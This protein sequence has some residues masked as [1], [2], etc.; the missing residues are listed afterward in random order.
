MPSPPVGPGASGRAARE[1]HLAELSV[2]VVMVLWGGNFVVVK[3]AIAIVPPIGYA[4]IRFTLAC[5]SLFLVL[6]WREGS[7]GLPRRDIVP[8]AVLGFLG[9][10]LYQ[11]LWP[12]G[13]GLI[14]AGD[15]AILGAATPVLTALIAMPA[16]SDVLTRSKGLGALV[17][18]IGVG[19]VVAAGTEVSLGSSLLG[20]GLIFGAATCWALYAA[21]GAPVLRRHSPLRTTAWAMTFG[22]LFLVPVG[23]WQL[24]D[25][26]PSVFGVGV[27]AAILYSAFLSAGVANVVVL[28]AVKLLGPTRI[29]AYQFFIPAVAVFFAFVF[30]TE[31]VRPAQIAGGVVI[32][33]GV[34]LTRRDQLIPRRVRARFA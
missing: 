27:V 30:L 20:D 1:R 34:I 3:A 9:F 4:L 32:L 18:F 29:T 33:V 13:L 28:R 12:V 15:A 24:R 31:P 26:E 6:R 7:V 11:M 8:L 25:V 2:L 22:T 21:F 14:P 10:G 17:A 19:L 23:L 5:V 16:G